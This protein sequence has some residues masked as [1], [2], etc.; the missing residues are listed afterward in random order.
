MHHLHPSPPSPPIHSILKNESWGTS[1][2]LR[3]NSFP[4]KHQKGGKAVVW[5]AL[6]ERTHSSRHPNP[7]GHLCECVLTG[8]WCRGEG[9]SPNPALHSLQTDLGS[10]W[11]RVEAEGCEPHPLHPSSPSCRREAGFLP[12]ICKFPSDG[13]HS[14]TAIRA[15]SWDPSFCDVSEARFSVWVFV[16]VRHCTK[17]KVE[18]QF[19]FG[20]HLNIKAL[21]RVIATWGVIL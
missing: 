7:S 17:R 9:F 21:I 8:T 4:L 20:K 6:N 3:F 14:D 18:P 11:G 2:R 5:V 10:S 12:G 13:C 19:V 1:R 15:F 16:L